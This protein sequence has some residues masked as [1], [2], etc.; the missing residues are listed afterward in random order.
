MSKPQHH[1]IGVAIEIPE[2]YGSQ[3]EAVRKSVNDPQAGKVPAHVTLLPPTL[4]ADAQIGAVCA[5]LERAAAQ[6]EPFSILLRGTGTFRPV[7]QVVF[8][9]LAMGIAECERLEERVRSGIL[10][11]D[12]RF[13]YHPHVTIA[14]D[15]PSPDLDRAFESMSGFEAE[16]LVNKFTLY[17]YTDAGE[18]CKTREF[19]LGNS[20][21]T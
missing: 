3:L 9:A 21:V 15:V 11:Q 2:P 14:H 12:L 4:L 10:E 1:H 7:S 6:L 5:H 13:N 17:T 20:V 8:V 16:F 18:W 19:M